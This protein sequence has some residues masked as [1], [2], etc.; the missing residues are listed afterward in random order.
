MSETKI[1]I[2]IQGAEFPKTAKRFAPGEVVQGSV[3]MTPE[4]DINCRH[5]FARLQWRT[6]GRGDEDRKVAAEQDLYQGMLQGGLPRH[7]SFHL[8]LP[9][10]PWSYAGQLVRIVWEVEVS[11]D[12]AFTRDPSASIPIVMRPEVS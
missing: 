2:T 8:R 12:I 4:K 5:V 10:Q 3:Q 1:E 6:E 7:Y 9:D 11:I